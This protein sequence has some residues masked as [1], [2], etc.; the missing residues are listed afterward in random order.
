MPYLP[1]SAACRL[2]SGRGP[3]EAGDA[4]TDGYY[5]KPLLKK[6]Y[7]VVPVMVLRLAGGPGV[8]GAPWP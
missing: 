6:L 2:V 8:I 5:I 7:L 4:A 1:T 3:P